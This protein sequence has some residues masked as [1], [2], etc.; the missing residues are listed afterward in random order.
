MASC[1][2]YE[3][4]NHSDSRLGKRF[5][6]ISIHDRLRTVQCMVYFHASHSRFAAHQS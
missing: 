1:I 5:S 3:F 6:A 2:V 4:R